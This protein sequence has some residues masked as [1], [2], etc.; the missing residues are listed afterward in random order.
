MKLSKRASRIQLS[1]TRKL[2]DL[3]K[4]YE[5]V[6][7]FTLGDPDYMTPNNVKDAA[8]NAIRAGKTKYSDNRGL[9]ELREVVAE[10]IYKESNVNYDAT[11]EIM[12]CV[13]AMEA[14]YLTLCSVVDEGDEV[15]IPAPYWINYEHMVLMCDGLP[16]IVDSKEENDFVVEIEDIKSVITDKTVAIILNS[17]SNPTGMVYDKDSLKE[18]CKIAKEKDIL[19]IW[20]EC[21]K[22][23]L[24]DGQEFVSV[25][26]FEDMKEHAV[27]I[28]SCSKKFSMT[29]WRVGYAAAPAELVGCMAK[30]QENIAACASLPS[31]YAAIEAFKNEFQ[32]VE[33][34]RSGFERRRNI[35]VEG[36]NSINGLS[37]KC[38]KGTFYVL[39]NI[40]ATKMDS[41]TF[42][43]RLLEEQK[44]AVVP[45]ITYGKC[46]DGYV[47]IACTMDE[48]K[49][50]EGIRR[51][52]AFINSLTE[53]K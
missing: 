34:M 15:I 5:D 19:I 45:G 28:N 24:F 30:F 7:D 48:G 21:Y 4:K 29:G 38:S 16:V 27:I 2:F 14:L 31:Q 26:D 52:E 39:V 42:A 18:I 43:Y 50:Q 3:A 32:E 35:L 51:I 47:R 46:C 36:I 8:I 10:K 22:S 53:E 33:M 37:C 13:G 40:K 23:I 20:D 11:S 41:V 17:P 1:H 6:I 9:L 25:L 12:I 44:V 49:I